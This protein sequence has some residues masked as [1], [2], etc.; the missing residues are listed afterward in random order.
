MSY[1]SCGGQRL[2]RAVSTALVVALFLQLTPC[3]EVLAALPTT[4]VPATTGTH[5]NHDDVDAPLSDECCAP[6]LDQAFIPASEAALL[7]PEPLGMDAPLLHG[8]PSVQFPRMAS[9]V[10]RAGA[11]PPTRAIYLLT[12]RFLL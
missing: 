2:I 10:P 11:P 1:R 4:G 12:S 6:W 3:C 7:F 5:H 9:V 8:Q